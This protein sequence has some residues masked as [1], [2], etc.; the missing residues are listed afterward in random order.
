MDFRLSDDERAL[1]EA[2]R[3]LLSAEVTTALVRERYVD[4]TARADELWKH[5]TE[6]IGTA[7]PESS[8]GFGLGVTSLAMVC[9]EAG[10][11]LAPVPLWETSFAASLLP[12]GAVLQQV[13]G[14]ARAA[15]LVGDLAVEAHVAEVLLAVDDGEVSLV[16]GAEITPHATVDATRVP[17]TVTGGERRL[18]GPASVLTGTVTL[19]ASMLG[20]ARRLLDDT[21]SYVSVREQFG[22]PIGSFQAVQHKL[23]DVLVE[24]ERAWAATYFAAMCVDAG[25]ADAERATCIAKASAGD[26]ARHAAREA[27]QCHGG[28]GYT[29]E[30]DLHLFIRRVYGDEPILGG[31]DDQRTRL[32]ELVIPTA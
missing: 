6:W 18:L 24:L 22:V 9:E 17:C 3:A 19:A 16:E 11:T 14:G 23:A 28:I 1:R 31:S 10:R 7:V 13:L 32:A 25:S 15:V 27:I 29:W 12:E 4:R 21:V 8:G 30:H 5:V 2:A 20:T 26:A